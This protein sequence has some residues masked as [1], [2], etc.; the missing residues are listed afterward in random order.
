MAEFTSSG[1][2]NSTWE[3]A[4]SCFEEYLN[5]FPSPVFQNTVFS[6]KA[7]WDWYVSRLGK[8]IEFARQHIVSP[9][10]S[11]AQLNRLNKIHFE[12]LQQQ[13]SVMEEACGI[14][15]SV[16]SSVVAS[17]EEMVLVRNL[18]MHNLWEVDDFYLARSSSTTWR[19]EE[20]RTV[21]KADLE[22]WSGNLRALVNETASTIARKYATAPDYP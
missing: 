2:T 19:L 17:L 20:I 5:V 21:S 1:V 22:E 14:S 13:L 16:Q 3:T 10:L 15:L 7:H 18:G 4:W 12:P 11:N 9:M 6:M 8:F